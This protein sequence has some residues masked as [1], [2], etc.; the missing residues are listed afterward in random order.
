MKPKTKQIVFGIVGACVIAG[1][2]FFVG[3]KYQESQQSSF[4]Q[5]FR[6]QDGGMRQRQ[7]GSGVNRSGF[8]PVSGEV[9]SVDA[10]SVTVQLPDESSKIIFVSEKTE[11]SKAEKAT[12]V[13][14]KKGDKVAVFGTE[15][16]D[17]SITA[18]NIQ[19]N[20]ITRVPR[21]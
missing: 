19:L 4:N 1:G 3:I 14:I 5:L 15:N 17:G 16:A 20:P 8:R 9:L 7:A 6:F 10:S 11:I 2:S 13:D 12:K 18:Q 21:Q